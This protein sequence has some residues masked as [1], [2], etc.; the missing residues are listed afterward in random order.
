MCHFAVSLNKSCQF[1]WQ[2]VLHPLVFLTFLDSYCI[3]YLVKMLHVDKVQ[4]LKLRTGSGLD[5]LYTF[6]AWNIPA[7][8]PRVI[9]KYNFSEQS[10]VTDSYARIDLVSWLSAFGN[11]TQEVRNYKVSVRGKKKEYWD[12]KITDF[13]IPLTAVWRTGPLQILFLCS[14]LWWQ[15]LAILGPGKN[16]SIVRRIVL[17]DI[18]NGS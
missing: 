13:E 8:C 18:C 16:S 14:L 1:Q 7:Q 5:N 12:C 17:L 2:S 6:L 3:I 9:G 4:W 10:G 15:S 11:C